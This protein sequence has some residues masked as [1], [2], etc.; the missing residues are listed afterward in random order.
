MAEVFIQLGVMIIVATIG[1]FLARFLRQPLI[2]AYILAG[3]LLGPVGRLVNNTELITAMS[4]A[5]IAF[6]LFIVGLELA[7][8]KIK[9]IG[10]V[11]IVGGVIQVLVLTAAGFGAARV[12]GFSNIEAAYLGLI[13]AFSSTMIVVKLLSDNHEL[14]TLHGKI[15][16]GI[17]LIQDVIA[18]IA[19][20]LL[21]SVDAS[22]TSSLGASFFGSPLLKIGGVFVLAFL[23]S[24]YLFP[25]L[26]R[27]AAKSQELL[28]MGAVSVCFLFSLLFYS[29]HISIAI[30]AFVAG[31]SLA[32]LPYN[33]EMVSKVKSLKDFFSTLFFVSLGMSMVVS[34][35]NKIV[36]PLVVFTLLVILLKPFII[37]LITSFF[38]YTKKVS[39]QTAI[40]LAQVSEFSIILAGAGLAAGHLSNELFTL[41]IVLAVVTMAATSYFMQFDQKLYSF[42]SRFLTPFERLGGGT[43]LGFM[44]HKDVASDAI[45]IGY[46]RIGYSIFKTFQKMG[47]SFMVVDYNPDIIR[48]LAARNLPC[49]YGDISDDEILERINLSKAKLIISTIPSH[50]DSL[51]IIKKTRAVNHRAVVMVTATAISDA[52]SLYAAGADYVILPHL[53]GGERVAAMVE[54]HRHDLRSMLKIKHDHIDDLKQRQRLEHEHGNHHYLH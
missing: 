2:P 53:L 1:A 8:K 5:G 51:M 14:D 23:C 15:I 48:R 54:E 39:F 44:P 25:S 34:S 3:F 50:D 22:A 24:K 17:L 13:V 28:F 47:Y 7:I 18:L 31:L 21:A 35:F 4:L 10:F 6:L 33:I 46:D 32:N 20:S 42:F 38:G 9:D 45:L 43:H 49:L 30:G 27:F 41:T 11:V 16:I 19:L 52:L 29:L 26:F 37:L 36:I 12:L 40:S